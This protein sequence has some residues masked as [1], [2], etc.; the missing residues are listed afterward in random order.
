MEK[1]KLMINR[2]K[3]KKI[4]IAKPRGFCAG[5]I[6]A[7]KILKTIINLYGHNQKIYVRKQIVHNKFIIEYFTTKGI[8]FVNEIDEI[9]D[10]SITLLSAHG[11]SPKVIYEA[12]KKNLAIVDATCPF[13]EMVHKNAIKYAKLGYHIIFIGHKNHEE[14]IG[15]TGEA[16]LIQEEL[17]KEGKEHGNTYVISNIEEANNLS[18]NDNKPISCLSQTTLNTDYTTLITKNL[19]NNFGDKIIFPKTPQVCYATKNRQDALKSMISETRCDPVF[20]IGSQN[21]S[22]SKRLVETAQNKRVKAYLID[23]YH[24]IKIDWLYNSEI[25]GLSSG[26]SAPESLVEGV[27][28]FLYNQFEL[29]IEYYNYKEEK[30]NFQLPDLKYIRNIIK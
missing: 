4:I 5:V 27:V 15:T 10:G 1:I 28:D 14:A 23:S 7:E 22:N 30:I 17:E 19:I 2:K 11:V 25:I 6:R 24:D 18:I 13:V 3:Q 26:A 29:Q 21:S 20:I 16:L 12:E 8:I 9:P